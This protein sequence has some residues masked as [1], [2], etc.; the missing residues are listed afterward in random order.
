MAFSNDNIRRADRDSER[1]GKDNPGADA[2][3]GMAL[4]KPGDGLPAASAALAKETLLIFD[5]DDTILPTTWL[6]RIHNLS[7]GF[8]LT[9]E[10]QALVSALEVICCET[11]MLAC[12]LGTVIIVTNSVPGWVDQSCQL[13]M[14]RLSDLMRRFTIV[15]RPMRAPLTFKTSAFQREFRTFR[16]LISVGD[17]NAER[18]ASLRLQMSPELVPGGASKEAMRPIKSV[19]LLELPTCQQVYAQHEMLQQRIADIVG[20]RGHLDL[21]SR[22]PPSGNVGLTQTKVGICSLVHFARPF[23]APASMGM[24]GSTVWPA[25]EDSK[26]SG[27]LSLRTITPATG[28][29]RPVGTAPGS[30]AVL[31]GGAREKR[32]QLPSLSPLTTGTGGKSTPEP[33]DGGQT[34]AIFDRLGGEGEMD[35][36][37]GAAADLM[38]AMGGTSADEAAGPVRS[39]GPAEVQEKADAERLNHTR[40]SSGGAGQRSTTPLM[41]GGGLWKV[42]SMDRTSGRTPPYTPGGIGKKRPVLPTG[43]GARSAGAVWRENS[44]PAAQ[45]N[46]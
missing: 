40:G 41:N 33:G 2:I 42:Q 29:G 44:A 13:F 35:G 26:M 36:G 34:S 8:M 7:G 45:R 43:V 39:G 10:S 1:M 18:T 27:L 32:Q 12:C 3:F 6:Q 16:N 28:E 30:P 5:W 24:G 37:T 4:P 9:K 38:Q 19:K 21:K 22:F 20:F 14:P 15:A 11:L 17:G 46:F 25:P 31:P 23:G